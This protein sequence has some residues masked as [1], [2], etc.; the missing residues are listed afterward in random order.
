MHAAPAWGRP[1]R[2]YVLPL[3]AAG[4]AVAGLAGLHDAPTASAQSGVVRLGND[5]PRW[6]AQPTGRAPRGVA[7]SKSE[8][9]TLRLSRGTRAGTV[10]SYRLVLPPG[11]R[12]TSIRLRLSHATRGATAFVAA[13]SRARIAWKARNAAPRRRVVVTVRLGGVRVVTV[14]L[15]QGPGRPRSAAPAHLLIHAYGIGVPGRAPVVPAT[16]AA[17]NPVPV[18]DIVDGI[19]GSSVVVPRP[20]AGGSGPPYTGPTVYWGARIGGNAFGDGYGDGP[21]DDNTM[22][23]FTADAGK[24]PSIV[25]WGQPWYSHGEPQPFNTA[26]FEKVR[27][28]GAIPMIDWSPWE[29]TAGGRPEQPDFQLQDIISGTYDAYIAEWSRAAAEWGHPLFIRFCHEMNGEWYPWSEESNGNASGEFATA[30]RHVHDIAE[31]QGA[32][33]ISWVFSPNEFESYVGTPVSGLYPGSAYVDWVGMS[34]YNW[35]YSPE[36]SRWRSFSRTFTKTYA[37][38]RSLAPN[39]PLM[40]TE[41]GSAENGGS[42][43]D[44]IR[45]AFTVRLPTDFPGVKAVVWWNRHEEGLPWPIQSSSAARAAFAQAISS[46]YFLS[47]G[48]ANLSASPVPA[49]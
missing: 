44:W 15:R 25:A 19:G 49:P 41:M 9:L 20:A 38:M 32:T 37:S 5:W 13:G 18:V 24:A 2:W 35:G 6:T 1:R 42:K 7:R 43:A 23:R 31:A 36:G 16:S 28:R 46:P 4:L 48:F 33:N 17:S 29:E 47:N 34:G 30:W 8:G 14:G 12:A 21:W 22:D 10:V 39:K 26:L 45:D 3:A 11:V 40:I 27:Q